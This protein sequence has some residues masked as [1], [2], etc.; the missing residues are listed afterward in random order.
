MLCKLARG[1][2]IYPG[3]F[4]GADENHAVGIA[5]HWISGGVNLEIQ[6]IAMGQKG[7]PIAE[8]VSLLFARNL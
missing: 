2:K 5:E 6:A 3:M 4:L 1:G 8:R 7:R